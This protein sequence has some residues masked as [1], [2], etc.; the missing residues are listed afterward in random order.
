MFELRI[1]TFVCAWYS[2]LQLYHHIIIYFL[3]AIVLIIITMLSMMAFNGY[4]Y[5][6]SITT[7]LHGI[8]SSLYTEVI[9]DLTS[10]KH[11]MS[12]IFSCGSFDDD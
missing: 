1:K 9:Y 10:Y 7:I 3:S 4:Y 8:F 12:Y 5:D 11:S 6:W 2:I